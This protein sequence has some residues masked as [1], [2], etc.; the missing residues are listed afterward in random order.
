[1]KL[2][3][4]NVL[5]AVHRTDHPQFGTAKAW[6][7]DLVRNAESFG[8]P[9]S[10]WASFIRLATH[11]RIFTN[12]TSAPDAFSFLRAVI[13]QP[14]YVG[15]EPG[16]AHP[17]IFQRV[18]IAADCSGDLV[19]DAFLAAIALEHGCGLVSFDRDFARFQDLRWE[20]PEPAP[21]LGSPPQ[22][23]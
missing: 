17:G 2:L 15:I 1:M 21:G 4:V 6:F 18:C 8:S 16:A 19:A 20:R 12:P 11:R 22:S 3:D 7:D 9:R 13:A 10:V 23:G 14:R 5:L